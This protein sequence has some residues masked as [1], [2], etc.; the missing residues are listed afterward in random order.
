MLFRSLHAYVDD[1]FKNILPL[2]KRF[3]NAE[4]Q[5][6]A[7]EAKSIPRYQVQGRYGSKT[8]RMANV[9]DELARRY[10]MERNISQREMFE[11][12]LIEFFQKYGY[13]DEVEA[14]LD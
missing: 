1:A 7:S 2:L 4:Y 14:F 8:M 11:V 13:R 6:A 9:L 10:S 12:A 3:Q 5:P